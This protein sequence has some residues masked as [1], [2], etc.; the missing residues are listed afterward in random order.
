M[1]LESCLKKEIIVPAPVN[2]RNLH[3]SDRELEAI[4]LRE[5]GPIRR[6]DYG[7]PVKYTPAPTQKTESLRKNLTIIDGYNVIFAW[8]DLKTI[9]D[10]GDLDM[11]RTRLM[12]LLC[13]YSAYTRQEVAVVFDAYMVPGGK[14]ERF[15][16]QG[17]HVV[18]TKE[19]ETGDAYIEKMAAEIGQNYRVRVVTSDGLIQ[20]TALR[21]GVLRVSANEFAAEVGR[22][23][24]R[25][26]ADIDKVSD[27]STGTLRDKL[28]E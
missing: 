28:K 25:I 12:D 14:G 27:R 22:V 5:F 1:H 11:A 8:E 9:A 3:I 10:G 2:A 23:Y 13:G 17:I 15:D 4:M 24:E 18:Y 26:R 20:L 16:Y 6:R 21:S 19:N 7:A